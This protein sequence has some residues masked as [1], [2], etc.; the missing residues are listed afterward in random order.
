MKLTVRSRCLCSLSPNGVM[1]NIIVNVINA[2][3]LGNIEVTLRLWAETNHNYVTFDYS[4]SKP[5]KD[6]SLWLTKIYQTTKNQEF[7]LFD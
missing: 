3:L 7:S 4:C 5:Y 1:P 2:L 6:L